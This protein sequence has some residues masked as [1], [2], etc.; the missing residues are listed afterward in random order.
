MTTQLI[1]RTR[2]PL[3]APARAFGDFDQMLAGFF[4]PVS[5]L[6][7][8][9]SNGWTPAVDIRE[10]NEAFVVEAELPGMSKGDV[11]VTF[12]DSV[13]TISGERTFEDE[14]DE[15]EEKNYRRIERRYGSFSR[16]FTLPREV[17]GDA[18][19]AAFK[20][21]LLTVTVPKKEQVKPRTIKIN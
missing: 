20:D 2:R 14:G 10:T 12:E 11:D 6:A 17:N 19:K 16:S 7:T 4:R 5:N 13:L 21:G 15:G 3:L 9:D 1:R 18:V 8:L